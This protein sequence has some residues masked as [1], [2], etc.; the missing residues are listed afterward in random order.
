MNSLSKEKAPD[1]DRLTSELY[2]AFKEEIMPIFYNFFLIS[3]HREHFL[4]HSMRP[5]SS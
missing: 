5:T 4:A 3:N 1:P 2:Q